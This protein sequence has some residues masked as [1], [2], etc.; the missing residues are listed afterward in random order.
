MLLRIRTSKYLP[1]G[2]NEIALAE[3]GIENYWIA[4]VYMFLIFM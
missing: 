3:R 1:K 4:P 2:S